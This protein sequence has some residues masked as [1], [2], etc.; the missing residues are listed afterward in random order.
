MRGRRGLASGAKQYEIRQLTIQGRPSCV[1]TI[2]LSG[3]SLSTTSKTIDTYDLQELIKNINGQCVIS[4]SRHIGGFATYG[5]RKTS[6][7]IADAKPLTNGYGK[8]FQQIYLPIAILR[9]LEIRCARLPNG[10]C[11]RSWS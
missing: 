6:A 7:R 9:V 1:I 5:L 3:R 10:I 4:D 2:D 8:H 11:H